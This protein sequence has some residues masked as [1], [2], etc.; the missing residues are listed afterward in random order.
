MPTFD[1]AEHTEGN[2]SIVIVFL[3]SETTALND[4]SRKQL[5]EMLVQKASDAGMIGE[6]VAVW[7]YQGSIRFMASLEWHD[8]LRSAIVSELAKHINGKLECG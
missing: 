4:G 3:P 1:V 2:K 6:V 5:R 8:Y 7:Q